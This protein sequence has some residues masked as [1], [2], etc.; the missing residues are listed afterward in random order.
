VTV[1]APDQIQFTAI[2]S[3]AAAAGIRTLVVKVGTQQAEGTF[4]VYQN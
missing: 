3:P 2:V 1:I 4:D